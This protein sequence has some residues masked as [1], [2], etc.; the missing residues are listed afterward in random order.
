MHYNSHKYLQLLQRKIAVMLLLMI[1]SI[2]GYAQTAPLPKDGLLNQGLKSAFAADHK[3]PFQLR[4]SYN[5]SPYKVYTVRKGGELMYWPLFPLTA[6]QIAERDK[7]YD[8]PIGQQ[9]VGGLA[10]SAINNII[11]GKKS[12]VAARPRF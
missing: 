7:N 6:A 9:I 3:K 11:Y 10:E 8:K 2:A 5:V 4:N 1:L 12:P